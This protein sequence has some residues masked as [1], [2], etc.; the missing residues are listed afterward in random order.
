MHFCPPLPRCGGGAR[1]Q[2][3]HPARTCAAFAPR[4]AGGGACRL[5]GR[6]SSPAPPPAPGPGGGGGA[7]GLKA[8]ATARGQAR[9]VPPWPGVRVTSP[10]LSGESGAPSLRP[11]ATPGRRTGAAAA[12]GVKVA[13]AG[14]E[15]ASAPAGPSTR[16]R[17][18]EEL[19]P[20]RGDCASRA[21]RSRGKRGARSRRSARTQRPARRPGLGPGPRGHVVQ[22]ALQPGE[23]GPGAQVRRGAGAPGHLPCRGWTP[24][25]ASLWPRSPA[26]LTWMAEKVWVFLERA[27]P[28]G[29]LAESPT[30]RRSTVQRFALP[31]LSSPGLDLLL[32]AWTQRGVLA[33]WEPG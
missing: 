24:L 7:E 32:R 9:G 6:R 21:L 15:R 4:P 11:P 12:Q 33:R 20:V 5:P 3:R 8:A 16:E 13:P 30:K 27:A 19:G 14:C 2:V 23:C 10:Y 28:T 31:S 18:A 26:P 22:R 29:R 1:R 17:S 25:P